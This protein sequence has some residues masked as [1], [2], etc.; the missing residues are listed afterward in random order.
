MISWFARNHVAANLLMVSL[1]F[2]G[3]LSLSRVPLEVFPSIDPNRID[4]QV[5]LRGSTPEEVEEGI[6]IRIEE[7]VQD[8]EGIEE[9]RST[10]SEGSAWVTIEAEQGYDPRELLADVKSRVDAI[11]T[12]PVEAEKPVISLAMHRHEVIS[13]AVAGPY[14]EAEVRQ[15]AE[16]VRDDLLRL[17]GV[18]QV[19]LDAVRNYEIAIEVSERSLRQYKLALDDVARAIANSSIDLSAGNI[20]TDGGDV[21]IRSKGQAYRR[22]DF[23]N[24]VVKTQ[25]NGSLIR[26]RD[27]AQVNDGF[28]ESPMRTRF[29]GKTAAFVE[30][31]RVGDQSAIAVAD[32]VKAYLQTQQTKMPQGYEFSTWRDRSVIV[33][34]R[35]KTL[36]QS[37]LQGGILVL[38][39]LTLFL[40]PSVALWVFVGI[41]VSFTGAFLLMPLLG[42]TVNIISLFGFILVL[43]IVVDDAIVTGEN[44]Y[45]HL[46]SAESGLDA[47]I[48][49][50]KEVALPVTFGVLTTVVAFLPIAFIEGVRGQLFAQIPAVVIP[51]L[52]F[53]L[54]ES[55]F[56]LPAHLKYVQL[57]QQ[58]KSSRLQRA[59]Q[60][61]ADR[62]EQAVLQFYRPALRW[63]LAHRYLTVSLFVGVLMV[64]IALSVS[65]WTKFTFFPRVQSEV[66]R[67][68]L[69]MPAGTPFEVTDR[70]V[71]RMAE[72]A[73]ALKQRH[74][75]INNGEDVILDIQ[76]ITGNAGG[77]R[78]GTHAGRVFF[79]IAPP[80]DRHSSV[81]SSELVREWRQL[82][83]TIPGAETLTF[84]AEIGRYSDP[85]DI[86]FMGNDYVTLEKVAEE[87]KRMLGRYP[88]VFDIGDSLSDGKEEIQIELRNQAYALGLNRAEVIN[89]VR[90]AFYG[91]QVQRIQRGRDDI[92]VMVRYPEA[93][94]SAI[95]NLS[96]LRIRTSDGRQIPLAQVVVL[97][98]GHS[99]SAIN[100]INRYRTLNVTA[101]IN[102]D[103]GNSLV[104]NREINAF[105]EEL[106]LKYPGVHY[107]LKGEAKEQRESFASL[108][109]G[110][111]F[112]LFMIYALLAIP[113]KS[114]W[115]PLIVMSVIPFGAIGA[116]AGHWVMGMDLTI[117]SILGLLALTG[118]VVN[119]SLVL[120]DFINRH[121]Q[122]ARLQDSHQA[123]M[124][125]VL[126]AGVVRFRPVLLTSLTTFFGLMPLLFEQSTQAQFLIPMAVSMGF[127]I[128][129]TTF[130]TLILVPVNYMMMEDSQRVVRN[131]SPVGSAASE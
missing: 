27:I 67:G 70:Y 24:I 78:R 111:G 71:Q 26:V 108:A 93:E 80:E 107:S 94:R 1:L 53:S 85:I 17:P 58:G 112:V 129:F 119:D 86:Q 109:I 117:F 106:V 55:K 5:T 48:N 73:L 59:Q 16:Q 76:A 95:A 121:K 35:L 122:S 126:T 9:I 43:G 81:T 114:Y 131:Y 90:Q 4:I 13:V 83:G 60:R 120:V 128:L 37:A 75:E 28:E 21:L 87:T 29:N 32:K 45:R 23:D 88:D 110:I 47:A 30:V 63:A 97:K 51:I 66:A 82:I 34:N 100:R 116:V 103:S 57:R 18:T 38:A 99:P 41:P 84:R 31:Y 46:Q 65:G 12:F 64:V 54:I 44:V 77:G 69:V 40:R 2:A 92:R 123:V 72:A 25:P 33:E 49:G 124:D 3:L 8:L 105:L 14:S 6:A 50:T 115:Q 118:V 127:G 104:L 79:E 113:F 68:S 36:T 101:D 20:K 62:F 39:L 98:P 74:R 96:D 61:F 89:Q 130:V 125:A 19:D 11:N 22:D 52:L 102:K 7:A 15:Q 91:N 56:V 42:I 10:S